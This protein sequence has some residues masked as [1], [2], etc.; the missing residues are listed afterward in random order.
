MRARRSSAGIAKSIE[1]QI[2]LERGIGLESG[3]YNSVEQL[4]LLE[5]KTGMGVTQSAISALREGGVIKGDDSAKYLL[6]KEHT[7][8]EY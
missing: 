8:Y 5:R 4:A 6:N 2:L 3:A 7:Q 1:D